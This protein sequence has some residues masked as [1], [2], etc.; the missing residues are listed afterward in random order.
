MIMTTSN[1]IAFEDASDVLVGGVNSPARAF[2]AIGV[3]PV[4]IERAEG[5]FL[6]SLEGTRYID[7][8]QSWGPMILGH[9]HP[10]VSEALHHA[11]NKGT[12]YGAPTTLETDM[13]RL[14][15]WFFP[16]ME[17]MR[18]V[19]SG[20]EA[21]MSAIRLARGATNRRK[22][23][24]FDGCYHGHADSLLVSAGSG[25]LTL[26]EP[27]S[28]GVLSDLAQHTLTLPY[29]DIPA[30]RAAFEKWGDDIAA[31]IVEPVVGNMG[32]VLPIQGFLS[33]LRTA[34]DDYGSLLILDEVM[35]GFRVSLRGA[36]GR[37]DCKP[38]ITV[39]GKV[40]GG[41]LPCGVYGGSKA[42]M[43]N[44]APEGGVYQ[45]GTLSGNPLAMA[46]G[47][48]T[49]T[50]LKE[51]DAFD[52]AE[53]RTHQ[54]VTGI[55]EIITRFQLPA[56]IQSVGTMWTLFW[57]P[58]AVSNLAEAKR[59]DLERFRQFYVNMLDRGIYMAPSQFE[60]NFVSAAHTEEIIE[61]TLTAIR[62]Y[63]EK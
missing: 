50:Q 13:A 61:S 53:K 47:I 32:V 45:A 36:Q 58:D 2:R 56:V 6:Y 7:Y 25:A 27:D 24:K 51:T 22:I 30:I 39:L 3:P 49:L 19:S 34:C 29:N 35:T 55:Q 17:K 59:T 60:A 54:L 57:T 18:F 44:V 62:K 52:T 16:G 46:A 14:I 43:A 15:Q 12:S 8:I 1:N 11:V 10:A 21:T 37:Y 41:G 33:S 63:C 26:G 38:D 48:V 9:C 23:V 40:V 4:F 31:I 5:P 42:L 28:K 20:T